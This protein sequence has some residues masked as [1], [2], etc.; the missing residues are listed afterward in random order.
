MEFLRWSFF[1]KT[2]ESFLQRTPT[3]LFEWVPNT[4]LRLV[5][6]TLSMYMLFELK[7]LF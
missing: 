5:E 2:V 7:K 3:Q 1:V 6:Y 4:P